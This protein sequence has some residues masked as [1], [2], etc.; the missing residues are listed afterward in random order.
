[1][2]DD[3]DDWLGVRGGVRWVSV[4]I[5]ICVFGA[6]I[7]MLLGCSHP[8]ICPPPPLELMKSAPQ[9]SVPLES[10]RPLRKQQELSAERAELYWTNAANHDAL[11]VWGRDHCGW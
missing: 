6:M 1:M 3:D 4:G 10:P 9:P 2:N 11:V 8:P 5:G 7:L